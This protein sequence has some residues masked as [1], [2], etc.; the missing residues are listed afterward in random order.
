MTP[1]A[2]R[3]ARWTP[4]ICAALAVASCSGVDPVPERPVP[5]PLPALVAPAEPAPSAAGSPFG[6]RHQESPAQRA[7]ENQRL[8]ADVLDGV[9]A[10][11]GLPVRSQVKS[12]TLSRKELLEV[13]LAK[14]E[15]GAP[16][17][18]VRLTGESLVA[19][20]LAP[21]AYDFEAGIYA[22][23]QE[24][25]AG[26][27]DPDEQTMFLLDDLGEDSTM[28]TLAHEL[29]HALQ[30]QT[31][32]LKGAL[33]WKP[34]GSDRTAAFQ[35]LVEGDATVAMFAFSSGD[36]DAIDEGTMR[37]VMSVGAA[38]SAGADTP[39]V[40]VR[41]LV[42]PYVDGFAFVQALRRRGGWRAVDRAIT[43]KPTS[44][45]QVLHVEKFEAREPAIEIPDPPLEP[46]GAGWRMGF[47]DVMGEQGSRVAFEE[48]TGR[49]RARDTARGWGGDAFAVATRDGEGGVTE[50][51]VVWHQRADTAG[52]AAEIA[53]LF[54]E[55]FGVACAE[56]ATLGP[57][58]WATRGRDVV[59]A[60]GPFARRADRSIASA[61]TCATATA[62]VKATLD[63]REPAVAGRAPS[64]APRPR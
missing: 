11:R 31:F 30:D 1:R 34:R 51:A 45:E 23:L 35:T 43:E 44:T 39:P 50:V 55:R 18:V 48:W 60:A 54:R 26:L 8:V 38:L 24:Q 6:K 36:P 28:Q 37:R 22:L 20:E 4:A 27:Y 29:V 41:S 46:L 57:V 7:L 42:A 33:D 58:T 14:Q 21:P 3:V 40:L 47:V 2:R 59:L 56:R 64:A 12:R 17:E 16:K 49:A 5:A 52:D 19:L 15:E 9:S 13:M 61:G 63:R 25:V 10:A 62:W 53:S 32:G